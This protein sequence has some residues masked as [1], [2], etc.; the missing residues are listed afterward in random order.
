MGRTCPA[1]A[2]SVPEECSFL[3]TY[4]RAVFTHPRGI[5]KD[6]DRGDLSTIRID[7]SRSL[8]PHWSIL[9]GAGP[10]GCA[11]GHPFPVGDRSQ[12]SDI[13]GLVCE[14]GGRRAV[15]HGSFIGETA[16]MAGTV[17]SAFVVV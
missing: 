9:V 5:Q 4:G 3:P 2:N 10:I 7:R 14:G 8:F 17:P 15:D 12:P 6:V 11:G 16:S 1:A 13:N